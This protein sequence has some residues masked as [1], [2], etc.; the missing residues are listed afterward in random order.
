MPKYE[1]AAVLIPLIAR[2]EPGDYDLL[3]TLRTESVEHHK[4]Q[5]SFPG[6]ATNDNDR[7]EI[8]TALREAEEE[9]GIASSEI[10][11]LGTLNNVWTP[12]GFIIT[13]IV[14]Y[15][16]HFPHL[17]L[18]H[19]EV[20]E[21]F[22]VPLSFFSDPAN[23]TT[24]TRYYEGQPREVYFYHYDNFTIWGITAIIIRELVQVLMSGIR[25]L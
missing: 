11:I 18:Q 16:T 20:A 15:L 4:G 19:D 1:K 2:K 6:G 10:Q 9:V 3:L 8:A 7:D 22:C 14:G 13:P 17:V 25:T 21:V 24:K 5:V 12:S 23:M